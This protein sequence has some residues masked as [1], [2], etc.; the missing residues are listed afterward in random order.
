[1]V[2]IVDSWETGK[3]KFRNKKSAWAFYRLNSKKY[4]GD[5]SKPRYSRR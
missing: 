2:Y 5:L 4:R 3:I 1:M